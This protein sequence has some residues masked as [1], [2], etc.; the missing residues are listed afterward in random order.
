EADPHE[1]LEVRDVGD[2]RPV[3]IARRRRI[4]GLAAL[5]HPRWHAVRRRRAAARRRVRAVAARLATGDAVTRLLHATR[6]GQVVPLQRTDGHVLV[7]VALEIGV[8][9]IAQA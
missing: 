5:A 2:G 8:G 6:A 3:G 4:G 9:V 1:A 7:L